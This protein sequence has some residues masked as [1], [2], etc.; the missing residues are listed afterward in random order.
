MLTVCTAD[1]QRDVGYTPTPP[2]KKKHEPILHYDYWDMSKPPT[3]STSADDM[4]DRMDTSNA[5]TVFVSSLST[6]SSSDD[7]GLDSGIPDGGG[8]YMLAPDVERKIR[9]LPYSLLRR[10][11]AESGFMGRVPAQMPVKEQETG[12]VLYRP[13]EQVIAESMAKHVNTRQTK[14]DRR[15]QQSFDLD[16]LADWGD[17]EREEEEDDMDDGTVGLDDE[18]L[19]DTD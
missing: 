6:S 14:K 11:A 4:A 13:K 2:G 18:D 15:L 7:D 5:H 12:M 16:E 3:P 19:M 1:N 17:D 10:K 8:R 9:Q